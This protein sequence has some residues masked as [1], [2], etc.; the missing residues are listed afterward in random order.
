MLSEKKEKEAA[1]ALDAHLIVHFIIGGLINILAVPALA[2]ETWFSSGAS[3]YLLVS[4]AGVITFFIRC[5]VCVHTVSSLL[6]ICETAAA[7]AAAVRVGNSI[8]RRRG[9]RP[10][11]RAGIYAAV[12]SKYVLS[13][14]GENRILL[15]KEE[16]RQQIIWWR[17]TESST[18][19]W[20]LDAGCC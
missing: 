20:F 19:S 7:A 11:N 8:R 4:L 1:D 3:H 17:G 5:V 15:E 2:G 12:R 13:T 14:R 9:T 16:G 10:I 18:F 6:Y